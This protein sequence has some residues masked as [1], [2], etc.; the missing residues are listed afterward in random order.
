MIPDRDSHSS[1]EY[2]VDEQA[3]FLF[4]DGPAPEMWVPDFQAGF[5]ADVIR[6][7]AKMGHK[8]GV[9]G[10]GTFGG[11]Q[12]IHWDATNRVYR[13]ASES[14]KDGQAAGW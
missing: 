3:Q 8:L 14:R 1:L 13:G 12:A 6:D 7:L 9:T 4:A 2:A 5:Y 11:Y 10:V